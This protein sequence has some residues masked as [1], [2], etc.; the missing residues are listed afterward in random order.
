MNSTQYYVYILASE[1][2][3]VLYIGVT[4]NL[5]RRMQEHR[6]Y[7]GFTKKYCVNKLVY[8]ESASEIENAIAREKQLKK[9]RRAK[10]LALI[11][12]KNP[13][14]ADLSELFY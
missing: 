9:W 2:S 8:F 3:R 13:L 12:E 5:P 7:D 4:N 1:N 14:W 6:T 10:K 11:A